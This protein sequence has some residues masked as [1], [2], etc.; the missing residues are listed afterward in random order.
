MPR[1]SLIVVFSILVFTVKHLPCVH[2]ESYLNKI[3]FVRY[4][5]KPL[6]FL[7]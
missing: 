7:I 1:N 3:A 5:Y 2:V 6:N 4:N